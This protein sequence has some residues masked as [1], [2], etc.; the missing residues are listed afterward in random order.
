MAFSMVQLLYCPM[1]R[2]AM[3]GLLITC[4]EMQVP[5]FTPCS[6]NTSFKA[7]SVTSLC[8]GRDFAADA[9]PVLVSARQRQTSRQI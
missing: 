1:T 9:Q 5:T 4:E 7:L 2:P 6:A 8:A 3:R